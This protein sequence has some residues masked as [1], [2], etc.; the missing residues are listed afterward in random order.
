M[1][2]E[3]LLAMTTIILALQIEGNIE[4]NQYWIGIETGIRV[5]TAGMGTGIGAM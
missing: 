3:S 2:P 4:V 1:T 5:R